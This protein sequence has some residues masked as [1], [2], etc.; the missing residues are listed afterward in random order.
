MNVANNKRRQDTLQKIE[1][2]FV[3]LLQEKS[4]HEVEVSEL[5]KQRYVQILAVF[6]HRS[7]TD[8]CGNNGDSA[9]IKFRK[10]FIDNFPCLWYYCYSNMVFDIRFQSF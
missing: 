10:P 4:L 7:T 8:R 1:D 5:C 3:T 9:A 2:V 6:D